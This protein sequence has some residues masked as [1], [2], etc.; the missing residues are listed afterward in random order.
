ME[1]RERAFECQGELWGM[2]RIIKKGGKSGN[3]NCIL[4]DSE[5]TYWGNGLVW[6]R[7]PHL[8]VA[9]P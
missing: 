9:P 6:A 8:G 5:E 2:G 7:L 3:W 1:D 4:E